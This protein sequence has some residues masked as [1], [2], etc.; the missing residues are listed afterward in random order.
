MVFDY[1]RHRFDYRRNW[2]DKSRG[3]YAAEQV[4]DL[5]QRKSAGVIPQ[6]IA[7]VTL[8]KR[9]VSERELWSAYQEA[10]N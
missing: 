1:R 10:D 4:D 3:N 7:E 5:G 2:S 6:F 8:I 9:S